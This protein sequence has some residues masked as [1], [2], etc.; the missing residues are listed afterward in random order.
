MKAIAGSF[1]LGLTDVWQPGQ[2]PWPI[3]KGLACTVMI[4]Q[5]VV[6]TGHIDEVTALLDSGN[7]TLTVKGRDDTADVVDCSAT[8]VPGEWRNKKLEAIAA[9][10]CAPLGVKVVCDVDTG[11]PLSLFRLQPGEKC[12]DALE[13]L[14]KGGGDML[15]LTGNAAGNVVI[16]R[17]STLQVAPGNGGVTLQEGVNIKSIQHVTNG[18][19]QFSQYIVK[20]F[21]K[22]A[23]D[24]SAAD[25]QG[26]GALVRS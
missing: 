2:A 6:I 21:A 25:P 3:V 7:H 14:T 23:K 11:P 4:G 13:R 10:I 22:D 18:E 16:T 5:D 1:E 24:S 26:G 9:D 20:A 8:N 19:E 17:P 15:L 12:Q